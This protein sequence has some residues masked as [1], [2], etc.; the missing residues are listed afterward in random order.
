MLWALAGLEVRDRTLL[1]QKILDMAA[2]DLES[3]K[4]QATKSYYTNTAPF[5]R[6]IYIYHIYYL[7]IYVFA[8]QMLH[9]YIYLS[10]YLV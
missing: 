3:Y 9:I 10:W 7:Y 6:D 8:Q 2:A 4:P 5:W 1:V